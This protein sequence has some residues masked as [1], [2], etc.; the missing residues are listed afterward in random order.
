MKLIEKL[1][2]DVINDCC[3][4]SNIYGFILYSEINYNVVKVMRDADFINAL[5]SISGPNWPILFVSPLE[6]KIVEFE[7]AGINGTVGYA[8]CVSRET[9]YNKGALVFFGLNNSE[10]DLPCFV[11]FSKDEK[12]P[13]AFSQRTYRIHDRTEDEVRHSLEEIVSTIADIEC[14]IRNGSSE[15]FNDPFVFWEATKKLDQMEVGI[16]LRKSLP[17]VSSVASFFALLGRMLLSK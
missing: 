3:S 7:N 14:T 4:K 5:S 13:N 2:L 12:D 6:K 11:V 10:N 8:R 15:Q 16:F 17:G 9:E 1:N